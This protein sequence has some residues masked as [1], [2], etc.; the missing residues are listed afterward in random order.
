MNAEKILAQWTPEEWEK[1]REKLELLSLEEIRELTAR[2][3][4]EFTGGNES[5]R[6]RKEAT[7]KE[8]FILVL[9]EADK[10]ELISEYKKIISSRSK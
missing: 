10:D 4:I 7:A 1:M 6:D 8:Q 9:D 5:I 2:V 3:G